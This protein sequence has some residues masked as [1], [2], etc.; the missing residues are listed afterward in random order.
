MSAARDPFLELPLDGV[1]AIEASAGT[2]KTFT[3]ATLV[4]RLVVE[5]GLRIGQILAVTFTEAAT[6]E[7]RSRIRARLVLAAELVGTPAG[8][9]ESPEATL[10]RAVI[11]GHLGAGHEPAAALQRRLRIAADEIDLAA[12]FTIHGF[13]A[14][15]LRDHALESGQGFD[16]PELMADDA[17]LRDA[18][19]ADLWRAHGVDADAADDLIGLWPAGHTALAGD[20]SPL[21]RERVLRPA[22]AELPDDPTPRLRRAATALHDA[23]S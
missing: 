13:C 22:L 3:L 15:V 16:A 18:I 11:D 12:I 6:Q 2:G 21:V 1:R 7:L 9:S 8:A 10:T 23:A 4:V 17:R 14:R 5:G 19:A 20:L